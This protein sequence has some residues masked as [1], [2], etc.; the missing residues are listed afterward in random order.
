MPTIR[1]ADTESNGFVDEADT[2]W[3]ISSVD[4]DEEEDKVRLFGPDDIRAGL[5]W[6]HDCDVLVMHNCIGHDLP[7]LKKLFDWEP[8]SHQIIVDTLVFSRMLHPKRPIPYGYVGKATHSIEAW[9]HRV[10]RAKPDHTDWTQYSEAMGVRCM[11]DAII[12]RLV[13]LELERESEEQEMFYDKVK[14]KRRTED[15]AEDS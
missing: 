11:D 15:R 6:L 12:N 5:D 9:G 4:K 2:L 7:L 3:C 1:I 8:L 13:L 14:S 10:G